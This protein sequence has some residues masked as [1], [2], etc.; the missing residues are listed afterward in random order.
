MVSQKVQQK[1]DKRAAALRDNL[2]KRKAFMKD[3]KQ[4]TPLK[5]EDSNAKS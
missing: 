1:A 2:K 5:Q 4:K 3:T